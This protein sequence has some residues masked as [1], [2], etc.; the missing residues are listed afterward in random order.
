VLLTLLP[1]SVVSST[2]RT[3]P[4]PRRPAII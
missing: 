2:T 4:N 3:E 1:N